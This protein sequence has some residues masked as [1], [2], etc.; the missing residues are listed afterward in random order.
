MTE[1]RNYKCTIRFSGSNRVKKY[2]HGIYHVTINFHVSYPKY[3]S[4]LQKLT[5]Y[6]ENVP[7]VTPRIRN[8]WKSKWQ[9][10]VLTCS[11]LHKKS[12]NKDFKIFKIILVSRVVYWVMY[13]HVECIWSLD[14]VESND[15]HWLNKVFK[16]N[17]LIF[18]IV[19]H[20][21]V[22]FNDTGDLKLLDTI[23]K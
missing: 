6:L 9:N 17:D 4:S 21:L 12:P 2:N 13:K 23:T 18:K 7:S 11:L 15:V 16:T 22:V 1:T 14:F 5:V 3:D 20:N 8:L 10:R 19:H